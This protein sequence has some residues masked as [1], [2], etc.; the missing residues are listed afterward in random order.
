M[1][2]TLLRTVV[3][4]VLVIVSLRIMGKRQIGDMQPNELVTTILISELATI[5]IQDIKQPVMNGA[6]AILALVCLEV[7]L[8]ALALKSDSLRRLVDG[9]PTIVIRHGSVDQAAM[10]RLRLTVDDLLGN[11]RENQVFDV[12]E[13]EY[14]LI[15][16]NGRMS[17]ML[18]AAQQP[19][20]AEQAGVSAPDEGLSVPVICDGQLREDFMKCVG[21]TE[22]RLYKLLEERQIAISDVFLMTVNA[23]GEAV[24]IRRES[25][26]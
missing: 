23:A 8:S 4:Y 15:E 26:R 10:R 2:V 6:I 17:V 25:E 20:T 19:L 11:L 24:V 16:T 1:V 21:M 12:S 22:K 13:V 7:L 9:S 14:A 3:L 18:K 5:P